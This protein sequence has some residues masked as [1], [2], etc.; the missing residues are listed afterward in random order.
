[1]NEKGSAE[2][3][4]VGTF[5]NLR[6]AARRIIEIERYPVKGIF[7]EAHVETE[8]GTDEEILGHFEH[9]GRAALYVIKRRKAQ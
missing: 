2:W 3:V 6:D 9:T 5:E 7:L 1:M 8:H 4:P